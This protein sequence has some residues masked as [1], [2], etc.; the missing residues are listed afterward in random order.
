[1]AEEVIQ[2]VVEPGV[3]WRCEV[4]FVDE[5]QKRSR[6]LIAQLHVP[7]SIDRGKLNEYLDEVRTAM[8]RQIAYYDLVQAEFNFDK[9]VFTVREME[10]HLI[11]IDESAR[12]DWESRGRHGEIQL[13]AA[14]KNQKIGAEGNYRDW[15]NKA[16]YWRKRR[17]ELRVKVNGDA[18]IKRPDSHIGGPDC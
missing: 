1:M 4:T 12:A 10:G 9:H 2:S 16:E 8:D 11:E 17:D 7:L 14:Q 5:Q 3:S 18:S 6:A 15:K 13:T